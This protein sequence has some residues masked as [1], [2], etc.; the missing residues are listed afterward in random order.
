MSISSVFYWASFEIEFPY[1]TKISMDVKEFIRERTK[2]KTAS[3]WYGVAINE[4]ECLNIVQKHQKPLY[5]F[6]CGYDDDLE[7]MIVVLH[8][9]FEVP[10]QTELI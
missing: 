3:E 9:V 1:L 4:Q 10:R 6:R 8:E 7:M 2:R 5:V